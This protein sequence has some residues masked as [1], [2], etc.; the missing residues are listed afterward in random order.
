MVVLPDGT[1]IDVYQ[2]DKAIAVAN[3]S[4]A[5][6][7]LGISRIYGIGE[8]VQSRSISGGAKNF[9]ASE[10]GHAGMIESSGTIHLS[11]SGGLDLVIRF[12]ETSPGSD[13]DSG[14]VCFNCEEF[15]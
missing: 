4:G 15:D 5:I 1:R 8:E 3:P 7:V 9:K 13:D 10:S 14:A 6:D 2:N 11:V 12:P